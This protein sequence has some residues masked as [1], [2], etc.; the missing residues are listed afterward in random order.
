MGSEV[1]LI[2]IYIYPRMKVKS[3]EGEDRSREADSGIVQGGF[4]QD[5]E[6]ESK[7]S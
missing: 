3:A 7:M 1:S 6:G 2:E 4:H 5:N